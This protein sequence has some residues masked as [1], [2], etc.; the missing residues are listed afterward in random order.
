VFDAGVAVIRATGG[1]LGGFI[2]TATV[3]TLLQKPSLSLTLCETVYGI[4]LGVINV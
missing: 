2:L 4:N 1:S 3:A